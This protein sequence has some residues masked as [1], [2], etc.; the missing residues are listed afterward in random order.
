MILV[1]PRI[2]SISKDQDTVSIKPACPP[3]GSIKIAV[4]KKNLKEE[5]DN[6]SSGSTDV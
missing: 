3:R 1:S 4:L 2:P 6:D 5:Y